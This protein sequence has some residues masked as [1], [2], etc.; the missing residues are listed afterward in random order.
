MPQLCANTIDEQLSGQSAIP[1]SGCNEDK[2]QSAQRPQTQTVL[3]GKKQSNKLDEKMIKLFTGIAV[4]F[5]LSFLPLS[6]YM[7][8]IVDSFHITYAWFINHFGNPVIYYV[9]D[10][11]FRKEVKRIVFRVKFW[12]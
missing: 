2:N 11:S 3:A 5:L 4:L 8:Y 7:F 9:L 1:D 10:K 12:N 6:L